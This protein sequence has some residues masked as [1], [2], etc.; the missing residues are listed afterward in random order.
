MA[1]KVMDIAIHAPMCLR[2]T[3]HCSNN[4]LIRSDKE[5]YGDLCQRSDSVGRRSAHNC[6]NLGGSSYL[7]VQCG[8]AHCYVSACIRLAAMQS[9]TDRGC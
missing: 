1:D 7:C 5:K 2:N 6:K 9:R 4:A 3:R 8:E